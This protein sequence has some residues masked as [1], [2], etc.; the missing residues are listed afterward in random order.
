MSE[1]EDMLVCVC[2]C[3]CLCVFKPACAA[4]VWSCV[5]HNQCPA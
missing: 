3:A 5:V 2:V 1:S 4:L